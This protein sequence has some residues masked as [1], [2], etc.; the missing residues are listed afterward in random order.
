MGWMSHSTG[1]PEEQALQF[2]QEIS[3]DI[4]KQKGRPITET[5]EYGVPFVYIEAIK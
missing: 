4:Y 1:L 3:H 5:I 2:L